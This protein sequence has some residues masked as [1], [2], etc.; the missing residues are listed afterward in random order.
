MPPHLRSSPSRGEEAQ[1]AGE[2]DVKVL[3]ELVEGQKYFDL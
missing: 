2:G 1:R 3:S